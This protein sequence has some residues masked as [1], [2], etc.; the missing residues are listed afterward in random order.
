MSLDGATVYVL[1]DDPSFVRSTL[2]L[3]SSLEVFAEGF[4]SPATFLGRELGSGVACLILDLRMPGMSGLEVQRALADGP[5]P[6]P[7]IFVSGHA[8]MQSGIEAMKAG[9]VDFLSKPVDERQ[10][11]E[12]VERALAADARAQAALRRAGDLRVVVEGLAPEV[13]RLCDLVLTGMRDDQIA[14]VLGWTEDAVRAARA[15]VMAALSAESL[16]DLG[17]ALEAVGGG[18]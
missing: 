13:R 7:V 12:A 10:L 6:L 1:D 15:Q 4:T 3:L 11:L 18:A 14:Q 16:V 8:D 5:R 9:A 17:R 2:R